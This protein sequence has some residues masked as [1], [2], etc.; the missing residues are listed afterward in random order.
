MQVIGFNFTKLS[1]EKLPNFKTGKSVTNNIE[2]TDLEKQK[3]DLVKDTEV[4]KLSFRYSLAYKSEDKASDK[5]A[6]IIFEG[7]L[8]LS[9]KEEEA[10]NLLKSWKKKELPPNF[11]VSIFNLLIR[12]C[13]AK[14]LSYEEELDLPTHISI[15]QLTPGS[16]LKE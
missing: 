15:P 10:K 6:E 11:R 5:E 7:F 12:K 3:I 14:A 9:L 16:K 2:F 4:V 8:M 1:A 13:A